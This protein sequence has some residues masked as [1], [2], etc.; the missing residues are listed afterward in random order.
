MYQTLAQMHPAV[1]QRMVFATGDTVRATRFQFLEHLGR[2]TS[3]SRS[4]STSCGASSPT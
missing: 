1:A 3:T 4:S 2:H